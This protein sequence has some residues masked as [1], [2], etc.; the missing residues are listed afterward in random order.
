MLVTKSTF[1]FGTLKGSEV[2]VEP[3][4]MQNI[5]N[6]DFLVS[7]LVYCSKDYIKYKPMYV[8]NQIK[9]IY[10]YLIFKLGII[11]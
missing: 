11:L 10:I 9:N 6:C 2:K 7:K 5:S 3:K 8:V 4:R 1:F